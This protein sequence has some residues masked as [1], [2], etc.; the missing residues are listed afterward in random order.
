VACPSTGGDLIWS[1]SKRLTLCSLKMVM[2]LTSSCSQVT[3]P[4]VEPCPHVTFE[5]APC[6]CES[7][8]Y[9]AFRDFKGIC[10]FAEEINVPSH[11]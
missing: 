5:D 4:P 2:I 9:C 3:R 1:T 6:A 11:L 8:F 7:G 10:G